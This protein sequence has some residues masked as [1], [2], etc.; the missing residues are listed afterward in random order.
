[1]YSHAAVGHHNRGSNW[2]RSLLWCLSKWCTITTTDDT[3]YIGHYSMHLVQLKRAA[4]NDKNESHD[5][6]TDARWSTVNL[7]ANSVILRV[8][9]LGNIHF[10]HLHDNITSHL[11]GTW[12]YTNWRCTLQM[13]INWY[14]PRSQLL[15]AFKLPIAAAESIHK[16]SSCS[17]PLSIYALWLQSRCN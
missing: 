1:M 11:S 4:L 15:M 3:V 9:T 17:T 8:Y 7:S 13:M 16:N 5:N 2:T 6:Q 12:H 10:M 14:S